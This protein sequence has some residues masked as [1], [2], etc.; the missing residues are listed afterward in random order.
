[1]VQASLPTPPGCRNLAHPQPPRVVR[2]SRS[3]QHEPMA[4][5]LPP[6]SPLRLVA[7]VQS[8]ARSHTKQNRNGSLLMV[9]TLACLGICQ[10]THQVGAERRPVGVLVC[11]G[12]LLRRKKCMVPSHF[13][14]QTFIDPSLSW[15]MLARFIVPENTC[16]RKKA[17]GFASSSHEGPSSGAVTSSSASACCR[18]QRTGRGLLL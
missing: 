11:K 15:Q 10:C 5:P 9:I 14:F 3:T 7:T 17:R 16:S 4:L 12:W 13:S 6:H 1:M 8:P 2:R 18:G